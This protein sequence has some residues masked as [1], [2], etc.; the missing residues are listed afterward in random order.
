VELKSARYVRD[1][2]LLVDPPSK[3]SSGFRRAVRPA[4]LPAARE[5]ADSV[6]TLENVVSMEA[7][8]EDRDETAPSFEDHE[9]RAVSKEWL[10]EL[11][12]RRIMSRPITFRPPGALWSTRFAAP[13]GPR[14]IPM[15]PRRSG[16]V[17][18]LAL[19][20]LVLVA[21]AAFVWSLVAPFR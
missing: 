13:P 16:R 21:Q 20:M 2:P 6:P 12:L 4:A 17:V 9:A 15:A 7:F 19:G 18:L 8:A 5:P 14:A 3:R 10:D 1:R 11:R